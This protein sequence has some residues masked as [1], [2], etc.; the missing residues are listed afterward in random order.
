MWNRCLE[1]H[2]QGRQQ[3]RWLDEGEL[4]ALTKGG[5]FALHA[6]SVQAVVEL[7]VECLERTRAMR[8]AGRCVFRTDSTTHSGRIRPLITDEIDHRLRG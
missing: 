1:L 7:F 5:Q 6:A 4:K 2:R 8:R 3:G